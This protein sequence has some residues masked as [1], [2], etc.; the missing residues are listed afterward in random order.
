MQK[1]SDTTSDNSELYS[2]GFYGI[3]AKYDYEPI[4]I[5]D[6]NDKTNLQLIHNKYPKCLINE[7]NEL[8]I[9]SIITT[10]GGNKTVYSTSLPDDM[11]NLLLSTIVSSAIEASGAFIDVLSSNA[12]IKNEDI[13]TDDPFV[14]IS[15]GILTVNDAIKNNPASIDN[16]KTWNSNNWGFDFKK[17]LDTGDLTTYSNSLNAITAICQ[18]TPVLTTC[19]I[20]PL[21]IICN[22]GKYTNENYNLIGNEYFDLD[23]KVYIDD[24]NE[25]NKA[26]GWN[27]GYKKTKYLNWITSDN[28]FGGPEIVLLDVD[29]YRTYNLNNLYG[30]TNN[31]KLDVIINVCWYDETQILT[32]DVS[33][34]INW[35]GYM[36]KYPIKEVIS[37][38]ACCDNIVLKLSIDLIK[39]TIECYPVNYVPV[40]TT[41]GN[42]KELDF[43]ISIGYIKVFKNEFEKDIKP[44]KRNEYGNIELESNIQR[45]KYYIINPD[46]LFAENTTIINDTL[47]Y[48]NN[49]LNTADTYLEQINLQSE[50]E[51]ILNNKNIKL[52]NK[53]QCFLNKK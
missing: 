53:V 47:K 16:T 40:I 41:F 44:Y 14:N 36:Y 45:K 34:N 38:A 28:R 24:D 1:V 10:L 3:T 31:P 11:S 22:F 4:Y 49:N 37:N 42:S 35:K 12:I 17:L 27:C 8:V 52:E 33:I 21:K 19:L 15:G 20:E 2:T 29:T 13:L 46:I 26:V 51:I 32:N 7:N 9:E 43:N 6:I 23:I 50:D 30:K 18:M 5:N 39:N 25:R 48:L